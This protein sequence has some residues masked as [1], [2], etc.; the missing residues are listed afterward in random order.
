MQG[1]TKCSII[2]DKTG[3][4]DFCII[5]GNV[6]WC[7]FN[8]IGERT[9]TPKIKL[10][11]KL[12]ITFVSCFAVIYVIVFFGGWKLFESGDPVL[13]ELGASAVLTIFVFVFF[14]IALLRYNLHI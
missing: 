12:A 2:S 10:L 13:I 7:V 6:K 3:G 8:V 11:I 9:M 1:Q 5:K 14:E 4:N